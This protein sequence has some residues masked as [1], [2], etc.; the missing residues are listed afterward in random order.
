MLL[1]RVNQKS[2]FSENVAKMSLTP[3]EQI[4]TKSTKDHLDKEIKQSFQNLEAIPY[5]EKCQEASFKIK[6][7]VEA[8][9]L[10]R[11]DDMYEVNILIFHW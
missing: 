5:V 10:E 6:S 4:W 1:V 8:T 9:I 3:N 2:Y 11:L 7:V